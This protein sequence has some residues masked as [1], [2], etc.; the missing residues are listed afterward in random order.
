MAGF[1]SHNKSMKPLICKVGR[2]G[3]V[4]I[5]D[6]F[7]MIGEGR[8]VAIPPMLRRQYNSSVSLMDAI[9]RVYE[10]KTLAEIVPSV[11]EDTSIDILYPDGT[12]EQVSSKRGY[13]H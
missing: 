13:D 2:D 1:V 4:S 6:H 7:E 11:G 3:D 12:L 8:Y 5:T 10:A 9:Y